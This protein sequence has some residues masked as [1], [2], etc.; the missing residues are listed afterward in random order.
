MSAQSTNDES[1]REQEI[2]KCSAVKFEHKRTTSSLIQKQMEDPDLNSFLKLRQESSGKPKW[3][4]VSHFGLT[5]KS[6]WAQWDRISSEEKLLKRRW[7]SDDGSRITYQVI[8]PRNL[9]EDVIRLH[10]D[11][12]T[13]SHRGISKTTR[14]L[15]AR[16]Y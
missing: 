1:E 15:Q 10:H 13:A 16:Y 9:R 2:P 7:E 5:L 12:I 4:S 11:D 3:K 14:A 6:L 8:L